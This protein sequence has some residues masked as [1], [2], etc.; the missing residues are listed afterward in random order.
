MSYYDEQLETLQAQ[1]AE[2]KNIEAKLNTLYERR[3][4]LNVKVEEFD[5]IRIKEQDDVDRF[6]RGSLASFFYGV[7]GKRDEKLD[8]EK[9]EAYAAAVKY[10]AA[11]DELKS[12]SEDIDKYEASLRELSGCEGRYKS[13]FEEKK[14]ALKESENGVEVLELENKLHDIGSQLNEI[15]EAITAGKRALN[16]AKMAAEKFE[17][18]KD[19]GVFDV[20]GGGLATDVMKHS[21]INEAQKLVSQLQ[22]YLGSFRTE[23]ADVEVSPDLQVSIDSFTKFADYFLDDIFSSWMVLEKVKNSLSSVRTTQNQIS[24]VLY[25]LEVMRDNLK[26]DCEKTKTRIEEKVLNTAL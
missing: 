4:E 23:L 15:E 8:K 18:A 1:V 24:D 19:W 20:V 12:V 9:E 13:V 11:N 16:T 14:N 7:V 26:E 25:K 21:Y 5:R 2:K 22:I 3:D 17:K 10:D 6:E